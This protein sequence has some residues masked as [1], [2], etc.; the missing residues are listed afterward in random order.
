MVADW[1]RRV[2]ERD[3]ADGLRGTYHD[4]ETLKALGGLRGW[5]ALLD[6]RLRGVGMVRTDDP[7]LGDVAVIMPLDNRLRA[8]IKTAAGFVVTGEQGL[9]GVRGE[10]RVPRVWTFP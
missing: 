5:P 8:A 2:I 10:V 6:V 3:P 1:V 4:E 9:W 7:G